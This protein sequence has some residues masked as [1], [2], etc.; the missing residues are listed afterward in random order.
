[1]A[2]AYGMDKAFA[3]NFRSA[4]HYYNVNHDKLRQDDKVT[5]M[6]AQM[7]TMKNVM[8]RNVQ[9]SMRRAGNLERMVQKSEDLEADVQVF[10]KKAKDVKKR[11][12]RKYYRVY[13]AMAAM[14]FLLVYLLVAAACG[15][16]LSCHEKITGE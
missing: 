10:Y 5:K 12:Q 14:V 2:N 4:L 11:K 3:P 13:A 1:M 9:M 15:W 7:E 8:G 6:M 16:T